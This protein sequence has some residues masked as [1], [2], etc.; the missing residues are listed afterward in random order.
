MKT[1]GTEGRKEGMEGEEDMEGR[2]LMNSSLQ[3]DVWRCISNLKVNERKREMKR[4]RKREREGKRGKER[5]RLKGG[6]SFFVYLN[7]EQLQLFH[8]IELISLNYSLAGV[9][10]TSI[11]NMPYF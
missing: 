10:H 11:P 7:P 3:V 2:C 4:E 8:I 1:E 9:T 6:E 5:E